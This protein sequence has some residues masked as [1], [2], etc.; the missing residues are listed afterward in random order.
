MNHLKVSFYIVFQLFGPKWSYNM[1]KYAVNLNNAPLQP[2]KPLTPSSSSQSE[3]VSSDK[4]AAKPGGWVD[5]F[6]SDGQECKSYLF[7]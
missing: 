3:T 4:T 5:P 1:P 6:T 2:Q 7:H